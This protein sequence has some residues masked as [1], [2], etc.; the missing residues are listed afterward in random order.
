MGLA[1]VVRLHHMSEPITFKTTFVGGILVD[2]HSHRDSDDSS[3]PV[4]ALFLLHGRK[5]T[6]ESVV[7]IA[8]SILEFSYAPG[9]NR[10]R[11]L[12]ILAFAS[13]LR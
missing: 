2:V 4:Y 8:K 10:K 11:D 5:H 12:I 13:A 9:V 3:L 7:P 1:E 6:T